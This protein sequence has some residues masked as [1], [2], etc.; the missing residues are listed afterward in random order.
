MTVI[1][2]IDEKISLL[3]AEGRSKYIVRVQVISDATRT[4]D[5][6]VSGWQAA[7]DLYHKTVREKYAHARNNPNIQPII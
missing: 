2:M 6:P 5:T 3:Q 7:E 1:P 4:Q